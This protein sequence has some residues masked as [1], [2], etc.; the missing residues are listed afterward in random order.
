MKTAKEI[1][2]RYN[3]I[4]GG[5]ILLTRT[6]LYGT[7]QDNMKYVLNLLDSLDHKNLL[8][9]PGCDMPYDIPP[10][11]VIGVI[12]TLNDPEKVR[13]ALE[14]YESIEIDIDISLPDY[15]N[16]KKPLIEVFT[17]DSEQC[18]A[19][20]YM[21]NMAF[22]AKNDYGDKIDIIEYKWTVLENIARTK[23]MG[24]KHLPCILINGTLK[25]SSIIPDQQ[26]YFAEINKNL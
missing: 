24:L 23:K 13:K 6:M 25:W 4:V 26:E 2:D 7:Q 14:T 15:E 9:A 3:I 12:E 17:L 5:N 1:T 21:K 11:N 19:C 22:S 10:D 20:T 8:I 18:A 16:L